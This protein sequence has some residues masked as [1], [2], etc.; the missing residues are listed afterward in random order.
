MTIKLVTAPTLTPFTL[1]EVKEHLRQFS[2]D[3]DFYIQTLIDAVVAAAQNYTR[4]SL[5]TTTWKLYLDSFCKR[6]IKIPRGQLQSITH[7]KY[8]DTAGDLQ[9]MSASDYQVDIVSE[10]ARLC[11]VLTTS[12]PTTQYGK[13]NAIEIQFVAGWV[14]RFDLPSDL[15]QAML[16]HI[17]HMYDI[18]EPVIVGTIIAN[19]PDS[20]KPLYAPHVIH[21]F[22]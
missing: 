14:K 7:V 17:S 1:D 10:P 11:P 20:M 18:R 2:S 4:R 22:Y 12:W 15:R 19:V 3:D 6:E 13:L 21:N 8:Y 9:T 16:Y 5:Y